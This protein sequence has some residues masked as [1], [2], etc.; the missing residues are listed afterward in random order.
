MT[1]KKVRRLTV[2]WSLAD[3]TRFNRLPCY[4]RAV[5]KVW[6]VAKHVIT[7]FGS[8]PDGP[9]S[10]RGTLNYV[11]VAL[12]GLHDVCLVLSDLTV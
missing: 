5:F 9:D 6:M 2:K 12:K 7:R 10:S 1:R 3:G 11:D 4:T 8:P